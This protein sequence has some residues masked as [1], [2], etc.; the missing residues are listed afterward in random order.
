ML[1]FEGAPLGAGLGAISVAPT[2]D[3]QVYDRLRKAIVAGQLLPR[4][5]LAVAAIATQ[6]GVSRIPVMRACQ[7][8]IGEGFLET[9]ARRNVVIAPLSEERALEEFAL[10]DTLEG[11]AA[12]HSARHRD[13]ATL[14]AL[15]RHNAAMAGPGTTPVAATEIN[16]RFHQALWGGLRS[17]YARNLAGLIW[18]HLEPARNAAERHHSW[19][20]AP[21]I[22][23]HEAIIAAIEAGDQEA[24]AAAVMQHRK[25]TIDRVLAALR[26]GE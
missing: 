17:P 22:A 10:L 19:N 15:R 26:A 23:E 13:A 3:E 1:S 11:M 24:A 18:D 8:L 14:R 12:R 25:R 7:R 2:K 6:L 4:Q 21:S 5:E 9:N 16:V 20:P